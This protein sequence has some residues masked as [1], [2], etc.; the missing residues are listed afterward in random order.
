M[1]AR[2]ITRL[3]QATTALFVCDI[4]ER[5]ANAIHGF[6]HMVD[7]SSKLIKGSS[8]L[9]VPIFATE[10]NPKGE[11]DVTIK[12][13]G[14]RSGYMLNTIGNWNDIFWQLSDQQFPP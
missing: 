8:I 9:Q 12:S 1:A 5:F 4:Q 14:K 10:Q 6:S 7:S 13:A 3:D 11:F 2:L